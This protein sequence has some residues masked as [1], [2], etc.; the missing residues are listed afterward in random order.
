MEPDAKGTSYLVV[1]VDEFVSADAS[2]DWPDS[3]RSLIEQ[4]LH[5]RRTGPVPARVAD[6]L[7]RF[8][9]DWEKASEVG[10][11]RFLP[12]AQAIVARV[13]GYAEA[14]ARDI[15]SRL[16][17]PFDRVDGVNVIDSSAVFLEDYLR[18]TSS[19]GDLYGEAPYQLAAPRERLLLRQTSC[20]Q[21]YLVA[22]D[23]D[24]SAPGVLPR[25]VYEQ[26]DS[27]RAEPAESLQLSFR[28]RRFRLPESHLHGRG[29]DESL[30]QAQQVHAAVLE[31]PNLRDRD[32][33]MLLSVT[34][35]FRRR[36]ADFLHNLVA[37]AGQPAL[38]VESPAGALCQDGVELDVEYKL[39][40][41]A[42]F[43]R[44]LSTFQIDERITRSFALTAGRSPATT[45]HSVPTGGV[46]R[47]IFMEFDRIAQAE[48]AGRRAR[49]PLWM[50]PAAVRI[51]CADDVP[52]ADA[53]VG[54]LAAMLE[55]AGVRTDIDDRA[56]QVSGKLADA[57]ADLVPYQV[58]VSQGNCDTSDLRILAFDAPP[59]GAVNM[60][61]GNFIGL[62]T[63]SDDFARHVSI[64][65]S[66][67]LST[68]PALRG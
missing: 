13:G 67:R 45:I 62:L 2:R 11:M 65:A 32:Y 52:R 30:S 25:C 61:V 22:R 55:Q 36:Y 56:L 53:G 10:H 14:R 19:G 50:A 43:A 68:K 4:E 9:F 63:E 20:L 3:L 58:H 60:P 26:S 39:L 34:A 49:L 38:L 33:A 5:G 51:I 17:L 41:S 8:G 27:F 18:L 40:D 12:D 48:A 64:P 57:A 21:K 47:Y 23:W 42:G 15:A 16:D 28:L 44:E 54:E 59:S 29:L 31:D 46:E 35:D 1:T 24:L 66:R 7:H 6:L 37:T